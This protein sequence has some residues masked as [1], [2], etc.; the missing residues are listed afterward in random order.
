MLLTVAQCQ[1]EK[2]HAF[3]TRGMVCMVGL[4]LLP[5]SEMGYTAEAPS[6]ILIGATLPHGY[7]PG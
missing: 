7:G 6:E 5:C 3:L 4:L 2:H 1:R